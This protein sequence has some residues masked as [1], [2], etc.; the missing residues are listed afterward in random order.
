M[1]VK[2]W[3]NKPKQRRASV[4]SLAAG[5]VFWAFEDGFA[6]YKADW[7][8]GFHPIEPNSAELSGVL[9]IIQKITSTHL[10]SATY[11]GQRKK[12]DN[13]SHLY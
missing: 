2:E 13:F 9:A 11:K 12:T 1:T 8:A 6:G 10:F 7:G 3:D 5:E 4:A